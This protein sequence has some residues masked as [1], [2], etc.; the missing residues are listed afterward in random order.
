MALA[1]VIV[2]LLGLA[3]GSFLNV[4]IYRVP[5]GESIVRPGSH[6][7]SCQ[8]QV[9]T[10]HNIPVFSWLMLK[11]RCADC[12][13]LIGARYP[14]VEA[15]T[16]VLFVAV[17]ARVAQLHLIAALP[18]YLYFVAVGVALSLIDFDCKRLPNAIVYP[19]YPVVAALL[20]I[21]SAASHDWHALERAAIG[22]CVL[23]AFYFA[24]AFAYPA[25]MGLGDVKLS[26]ILGALLAYLSWSALLFGAF[27]GFL[28][29]ALIGVGVIVSRRGD[30]KT[31]LPFGP[32]MIAG[33]LAA[34]FAAEPLMHFYTHTAGAG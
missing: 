14:L 1:V 12:A 26:G 31:A 22:G 25:G 27:A 10:R 34:I 29:C 2:G 19:S 30:R 4:V 23:F 6:C 8:G 13:A 33:V 3:I 5:R 16:A 7:P 21:A 15:G 20:M 28:F 9:R 18:A 32:F 17:T 11:G 24:L